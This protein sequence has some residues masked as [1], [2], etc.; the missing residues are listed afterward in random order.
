MVIFF[1]LFIISYVAGSI[2]FSILL[3]KHIRKEDPRQKFSGNAGVTNVYRQAGLVWAIA[4]LILD[5]GR[6]IGVAVLS[7]AMLEPG[8]VPFIGF[9]LILGN[10]FPCFHGFK[11]GKG[12]ANYLG[13][14][15]WLAPISAVIGGVAWLLV[16]AIIR[17]PFIASFCMV[18]ILAMGTLI[19]FNASPPAI[20]GVVLTALFIFISHKQNMV[21]WL[22]SD[23][24]A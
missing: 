18:I 23:D 20:I 19:S 2:N 14:T 4:I 8:F 6:A 10:R 9:S 5:M 21:E 24:T 12:V 22:Q 17:I 1:L 16:N 15:L 7:M 13:F 3:F 11:G